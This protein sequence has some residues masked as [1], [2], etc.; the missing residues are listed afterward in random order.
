[1]NKIEQKIYGLNLLQL[2]GVSTRM[3]R[4]WIVGSK[5]NCLLPH[6]Y[7]STDNDDH[8]RIH[9]AYN[10]RNVLTEVDAKLC[11]RNKSHGHHCSTIDN[12]F[13]NSNLLSSS[14]KQWIQV[15]L[16]NSSRNLKNSHQ[17]APRAI[18]PIINV[19]KLFI[20]LKWNL[21]DNFILR[22]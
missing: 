20:I 3:W 21:K 5:G 10:I 14:S 4:I 22:N 1:M 15:Q 19:L 9:I 13:N 6:N 17:Q 12:S 18:S 8:K 2:W 11:N 7:W 16:T